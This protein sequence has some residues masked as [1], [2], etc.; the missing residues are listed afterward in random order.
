MEI[1][2]TFNSFST[3]VNFFP[4]F[5]NGVSKRSPKRRNISEFTQQDGRRKRKQIT[6]FHLRL[7]FSFFFFFYKK[8]C[9]KESEVWRKVIQTKL[10]SRLSHKVC[11]L[12]PSPVQL[13]TF[14]DLRNRTA[15]RRGRQIACAWRTWQGYN[16]RILSWSSLTSMFSGL[17]QK[18]LFKGKWSLAKSYFKQNYCHACHTRFAVFFL[19]P[20]CCVSSLFNI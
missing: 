19:L 5:E 20:S 16:L 8:I 18:D 11:R 4:F 12:L 2:S 6:D 17:L 15:G 7:I 3:R 1:Q 13:R 10:L 14:I 9:L